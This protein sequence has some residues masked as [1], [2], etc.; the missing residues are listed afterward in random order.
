MFTIA[1][2]SPRVIVFL[3]IG[4]QFGSKCPENW[5]EQ[6]VDHGMEGL[7]LTPETLRADGAGRRDED[8][9][10]QPT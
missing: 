6:P 1:L 5:Q 2:E 8:S 9:L 4:T 10:H 7:G 3:S